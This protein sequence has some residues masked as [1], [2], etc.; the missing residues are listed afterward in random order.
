MEIKSMGNT[1]CMVF[2]G[3]SRSG[4]ICFNLKPSNK[5]YF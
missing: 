4:R 5:Q 3:D 2:W 1:H